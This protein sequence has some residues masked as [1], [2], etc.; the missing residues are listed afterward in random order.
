MTQLTQ[1]VEQFPN[2]LKEGKEQAARE[3][4]ERANK[5]NTFEVR[6]LKEQ[7]E[8]TGNLTVA[9]S[10]TLTQRIE[11]LSEENNHLRKQLELANEKVVKVASDAIQGAQ[12]R[13]MP[14]TAVQAATGK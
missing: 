5:A 12:Q 8:N 2:T 7:I 14:V 3:A 9:E 13:I 4:T 6:A 11:I 1:E 10:K